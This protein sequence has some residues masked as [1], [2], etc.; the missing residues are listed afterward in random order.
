[1]S[2]FRTDDPERDFDRYDMEQARR[3]ARLPVCEKCKKRIYDD[4]YYEDDGEILC[5]EH[6]LERYRKFTEDYIEI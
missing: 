2:Y 6:L 4:H 5:E 1:M 3:E